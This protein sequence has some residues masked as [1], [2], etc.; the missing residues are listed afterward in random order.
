M[1]FHPESR[2]GLV[3]A[4]D[5]VRCFSTFA[6]LF[7]PVLPEFTQFSPPRPLRPAELAATDF[8]S[9]EGAYACGISSVRVD[10]VEEKVLQFQVE[11]RVSSQQEL[12]VPTALI[13]A[14][15]NVFF[16]KKKLGI[17]AFPLVQFLTPHEGRYEYLWN[18]VNI[19][20]RTGRS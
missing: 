6:R 19:W 11:R 5:R 4:G 14:V 16:P 12:A 17:D 3:L 18:G 7:S 2:S 9:F 15:Q 20:R 13:P 10:R 8:A 1:R